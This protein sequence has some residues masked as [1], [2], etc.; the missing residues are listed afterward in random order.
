MKK[1]N[2]LTD[3]ILREKGKIN[4]SWGNLQQYDLKA[5][6]NFNSSDRFFIS[7]KELIRYIKT[8]KI[9][10][11]TKRIKQDN[12][13]IS[14]GKLSSNY[15]EKIHLF[16]GSFKVLQFD[17]KGAQLDFLYNDNCNIN[18][19]IDKMGWVDIL[20]Y[21]KLSDGLKE[22]LHLVLDS[23]EGKKN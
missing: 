13:T 15:S 7:N 18:I 9:H 20:I 11:I 8:K 6:F 10:S 14:R 21:K 23:K 3:S 4:D 16:S 5:T 22:V 19:S 1:I 2:N 17:F 12:K